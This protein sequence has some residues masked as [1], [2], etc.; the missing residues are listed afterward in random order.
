MWLNCFKTLVSFVAVTLTAAVY[1]FFEPFIF[2]YRI[3]L[4]LISSGLIGLCIGDFLMLSA[5]KEI[6]GS[7]MVMLFGLTPFLTGIG[8]SI[9]FNSNLKMQSWIGVFFMVLCLIFL[10][11]EQYKKSGHWHFKGIL[12]GISAVLLDSIGLILTKSIYI[13]YPQIN[14]IYVNFYRLIGALI[15]FLIIQTFI[16][17]INIK[18]TFL[19]LSF[20]IKRKAIISSLL[21]TYFSLLLFL[22][23]VS[24]GHLSVVSSVAGTGPLFAKIFECVEEKKLPHVYWFISFGF[25]IIGF[26]FF[27]I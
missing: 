10:S 17:P 16:K 15:G 23:A 21:G 26:Y 19:D 6:G 9:F 22:K 18:Q 12:F 8:S 7:R 27:T 13:E 4:T 24:L 5:M 14:T 2:D 3:L 1:L 11:L 20:N 25:M